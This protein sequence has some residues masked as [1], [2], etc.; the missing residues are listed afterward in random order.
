MI[1]CDSKLSGFVFSSGVIADHVTKW[2]WDLLEGIFLGLIKIILLY[3][4]KIVSVIFN[5]FVTL[6]S[7]NRRIEFEPP[8]IRFGGEN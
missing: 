7:K 2:N 4:G 5:F 6:K 1:N 8:I 3:N